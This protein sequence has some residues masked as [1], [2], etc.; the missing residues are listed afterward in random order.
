[1]TTLVRGMSSCQSP[2]A[3]LSY[4]RWPTGLDSW[5]KQDLMPTRLD[6]AAWA[7]VH[8]TTYLF[9]L[10]IAHSA[11]DCSCGVL[12]LLSILAVLLKGVHLFPNYLVFL[13]TT[14]VDKEGFLSR[15]VREH[16]R[17]HVCITTSYSPLRSLFLWQMSFFPR[18]DDMEIREPYQ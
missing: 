12:H 8:F 5:N 10:D 4:H 7:L 9:L 6:I 17:C 2:S 15:W 16:N 18:G 1:M 3:R 14:D 11:F 13:F